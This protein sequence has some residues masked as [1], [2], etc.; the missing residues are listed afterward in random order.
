M[1]DPLATYRL[2]GSRIPSA[3]LRRQRQRSQSGKPAETDDE[4]PYRKRDS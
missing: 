4:L 1:N 3:G 2:T